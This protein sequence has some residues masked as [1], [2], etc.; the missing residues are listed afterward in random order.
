MYLNLR[1]KV[2]IVTGGGGGLGR[3]ICKELARE[4]VKVVL[5]YRSNEKEI[6]SFVDELNEKYTG[7]VVAVKGDLIDEESIDNLFNAAIEEFSCV[8]ILVNNA[9]VWPTAYVKDMEVEDF[10]RTMIINLQVPFILSKKMVNHLIDRESKGKIINIVSQ[11]AFH[12]STTGHAHYAASKGGL[13]TF[14]VSLAREVAKY[15]INVTAVA[16]GIMRTKMNEQQLNNKED[17]DYYM[18]RIPL[19]R[20]SEPEEVA[21]TVVFLASNRA[22]Y[23]TGATI[24]VT[25][26]MLMR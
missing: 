21:Y 10:Q 9:G 13:V 19:G 1:G 16:P 8:D 23:I 12:G 26:G 20:I 18:K 4:G 24:D 2:A 25:G 22:D 6:S 15:G 11:A 3:A 5:S 14:T 17:E 7:K